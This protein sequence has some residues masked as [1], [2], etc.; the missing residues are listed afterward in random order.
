MYK[1]ESDH[2]EEFVNSFSAQRNKF[3]DFCTIRFEQK[4]EGFLY[5]RTISFFTLILVM[6][7]FVDTALQYIDFGLLDEQKTMPIAITTAHQAHDDE[8]APFLLTLVR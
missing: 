8:S 5:V 3:V 1:R 7:R 2:A 6:I 4:Y